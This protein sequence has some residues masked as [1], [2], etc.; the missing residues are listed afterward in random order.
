M[1]MIA[2]NKRPLLKKLL[3]RN[4]FIIKNK[5]FSDEFNKTQCLPSLVGNKLRYED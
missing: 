3:G 4:V 1:S 5:M 2:L